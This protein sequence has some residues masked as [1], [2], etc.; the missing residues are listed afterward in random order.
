MGKYCD[1]LK[2]KV[3]KDYQ[4]GFLGI[5]PVA[6]KYGISKS[7]V[8]RWIQFYEEFGIEGLL[9]E[10]IKQ[11]YSIQFKLDVLNFIERTGSSEMEAALEFR[12]KDPA[13]IAQWKK[14]FRKSG[15]EGLN[16]R[17]GRHPMS[18]TSKPSKNKQPKE[19]EM[20]YEQKLERENELLRLEVAYLKK[21][22]AFQ[23]DPE[24][25]LEKHKQ[26]YHSNSKKNSN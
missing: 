17:K 21:L 24:G 12:M 11:S 3:V 14:A 4:D 15:V 9:S 25:Y 18:D 8:G 5:R 7:V 22:R 6:K 10:K 20:S 26:R 16:T 1:E 2:I 13:R 19:K 23:M